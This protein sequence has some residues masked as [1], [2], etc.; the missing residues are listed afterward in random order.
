[1]AKITIVLSLLCLAVCSP[2]NADGKTKVVE[3]SAKKAPEWLMSATDGFMVVTVEAP[4]IAEAQTR[5][6]NE[7]TERILQSVAS[8]VTLEQGNTASE[9]YRNGSIE[10]TD[11]YTRT[12]RIRAA[13]MPFLKGVSLSK[14]QDLYWVKLLDKETGTEHYEYSVKYPYTRMDQRMLQAEFE[15]LDSSKQGELRDLEGFIDTFTSIDDIRSAITRLDAL[16]EYFVD[17]VRGTR[18]K[19]LRARYRDLY[20]SLGI[21]GSIVSS[22]MIRCGLTVGG[23]TVR[24]SVAPTATSN[25]ASDISVTPHD[26]V[27]KVEFDTSDCLPDEENYVTVAFRINGRRIE[28]RFSLRQSIATDKFSV[29]PEGTVILKA[30]SIIADSGEI[31]N[32]NI[33]FTLNNRGDTDFGVKSLEL[34]VPGINSLVL[35]DDIDAVYTTRG[36]VKMA[37]R[38]EG[39]IRIGDN[40][41]GSQLLNGYVSVVNPLSQAIERVRIT[42]PFTVNW[43]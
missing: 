5:A 39:R 11:I 1:M 36:A 12:S 10:S 7:L 32:L 15:E 26:G 22:G 27:F 3:R 33:S 8:N 13:N 17:N 16:E 23:R 35:V 31:A 25:C 6:L 34:K 19:G 4:S 9:E 30:D 37:C 20:K 43:H 21:T 24:S 28:R 29:V 14:A 41:G 2:V 38:V 40:A 42:L 18:V